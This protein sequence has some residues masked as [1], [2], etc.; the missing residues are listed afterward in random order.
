MMLLESSRW[1]A[2]SSGSLLAMLMVVDCL[3]L[4]L[5]DH[6]DLLLLLHLA[7]GGGLLHLLDGHLVHVWPGK[8]A[9]P[10]TFV[11]ATSLS[12]LPIVSSSSST[13]EEPP[14]ILTL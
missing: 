1:W 7:L 12:E 13:L 3:I 10:S 8:G 11:V 6:D 4:L 2:E 9:L 14:R 5:L